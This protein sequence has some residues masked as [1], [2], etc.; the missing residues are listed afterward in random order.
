MGKGGGRGGGKGGAKEKTQVLSAYPLLDQ[1]IG[2]SV[3]FMPQARPWNA[4]HVNPPALGETRDTNIGRLGLAPPSEA[5]SIKEK[6]SAHPAKEKPVNLVSRP[7]ASVTDIP[8][9]SAAAKRLG[10]LGD[11][12]QPWKPVKGSSAQ[13]EA[14]VSE[15][16]EAEKVPVHHFTFPAMMW[17][18]SGLIFPPF[19]LCGVRYVRSANFTAKAFGWAALFVFG[20]Y[21]TVG[22]IV[23]AS[24]WRSDNWSGEDP[25]CVQYMFGTSSSLGTELGSALSIYG[26]NAPGLVTSANISLYKVNCSFMAQVRVLITHC[27]PLENKHVSLYIFL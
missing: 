11:L 19:L 17:F 3:P 20:I 10:K 5:S 6:E 7:T 12:K 22:L 1:P 25:A 18:F 13:R 15:I 21:A 4:R 9:A 24:L 26:I 23:G 27:A 2:T 14:V 16:M 8:G